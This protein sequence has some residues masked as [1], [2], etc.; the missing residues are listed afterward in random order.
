MEGERAS[1][2]ATLCRDDDVGAHTERVNDNDEHAVTVAPVAY[3]HGGTNDAAQRT[4]TPAASRGFR[5]TIEFA[6]R[7]RRLAPV[8]R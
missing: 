6:L 1:E 2:K 5:T 3:I 4:M 7:R 8:K